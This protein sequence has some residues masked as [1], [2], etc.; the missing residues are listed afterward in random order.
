VLDRVDAHESLG[1]KTVETSVPVDVA[2]ETD[3]HTVREYLHHPT[4]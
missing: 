1:E 2:P 3:R 4:E